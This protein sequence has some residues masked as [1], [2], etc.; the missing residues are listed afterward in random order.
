MMPSTL[1]SLR[2][3][4]ESISQELSSLIL[5]QQSLMKLELEQ[6]GNSSIQ[7]NS[8]PERKM[9]PTTSPE[10]TTPLVK[11][12]ST[13]AWTELENSL[14]TVPVYKVSWYSTPSEVVPDL[15]WDL[16][17]WKDFPLIMVR[18]PNWDSLFTHPHKSQ[19]PLLNHTTLS[20]PLSLC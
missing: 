1:S 8:S 17:F 14:I 10:A 15:V 19:P 13:F 3:V 11:K 16:Y 9:T 7:S 20:Y 12:S 2:L 5:N 6:T 4:L 18:N